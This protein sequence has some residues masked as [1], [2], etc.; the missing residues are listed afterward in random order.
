[1]QTEVMAPYLDLLRASARI[2]QDIG[3]GLNKIANDGERAAVIEILRNDM[4]EFLRA[5]EK[6][7]I[8][9]ALP[10]AAAHSA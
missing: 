10:V 2:Q 7:G 4:P 1:M 9:P 5:A 8:M 6:A 3:S